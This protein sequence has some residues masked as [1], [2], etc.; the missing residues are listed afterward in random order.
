MTAGTVATSNPRFL[1]IL[2]TLLL[3]DQQQ[4]S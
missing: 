3:V 4:R 1:R 2:D